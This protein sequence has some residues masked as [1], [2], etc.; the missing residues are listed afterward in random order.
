MIIEKHGRLIDIDALTDQICKI[1]PPTK[2]M[3]SPKLI[4][5]MVKL[6]NNAPVIV[7]RDVPFEILDEQ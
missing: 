7:P 3:D 2:P 4:E 6:I 5:Q 1:S